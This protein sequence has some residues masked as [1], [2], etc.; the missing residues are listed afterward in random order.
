MTAALC[1]LSVVSCGHAGDVQSSDP[2]D[3]PGWPTSS[4]LVAFL[5]PGLAR[6]RMRR[7]G[8]DGVVVLRQVFLSFSLSLSLVLFGA[9]LSFVDNEQGAALP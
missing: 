2:S 6:R 3:D 5:V 8:I 4:S 7:P 9:V 1:S